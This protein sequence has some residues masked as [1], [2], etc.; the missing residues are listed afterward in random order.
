VSDREKAIGSH[1]G[2]VYLFDR[3]GN[4]LRRARP[5]GASVSDLS[6]DKSGEYLA[7]A[8]ID[9]LLSLQGLALMVREGYRPRT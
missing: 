3:K 9:G 6:M 1:N 5:H 4:E 8:S 7:S 2:K